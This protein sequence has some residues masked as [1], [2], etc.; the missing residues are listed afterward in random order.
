MLLDVWLSE[1][2]SYV[3]CIRIYLLLIAWTLLFEVSLLYQ[4]LVTA[5]LMLCCSSLD[6]GLIF[7]KAINPGNELIFLTCLTFSH[8]L[9]LSAD[10]YRVNCRLCW[11]RHVTYT[12][13][14]Y[15]TNCPTIFHGTLQFPTMSMN[16]DSRQKSIKI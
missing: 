14:E 2:A 8:L 1:Q 4:L 11:N 5:V 3:P 9:S 16:H 15:A 13:I 7:S 12:W 10:A 6:C